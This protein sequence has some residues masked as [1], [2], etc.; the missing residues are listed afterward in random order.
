MQR[1]GAQRLLQKYVQ[2]LDEVAF[3]PWPVGA[4]RVEVPAWFPGF[5]PPVDSDHMKHNSNIY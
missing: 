2:R 5:A 3:R 4:A 1:V